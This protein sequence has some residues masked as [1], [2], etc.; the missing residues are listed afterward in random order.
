VGLVAWLARAEHQRE[1]VIVVHG[2]GGNRHTSLA[3]ASFLFPRF[4]TLL[5]DLRGHGES[6]GRHT[7]VGYLERL[8]VA[9]AVDYLRSAGFERVG[10]LGISMGAVTALLAAADC[11]GV[12]AVVADSPFAALQFAVQEGARLRGYPASI[13]RPLAYLSCRTAA[14]RLRHP[15]RAGDPLRVVGAIAPRPIMLIHG[16][17]DGLIP[18]ENAHRLYAAA[19]DPKELWTLPDVA[20]ARALEATPHYYSRRVLA[21]FERWLGR[22][23]GGVAQGSGSSSSSTGLLK[24]GEPA[25]QASSAQVNQIAQD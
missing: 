21:Y 14:W 10:V 20:H 12:D 25:S 13:V 4:A 24:I 23:G 8:D 5:L 17:A 15:L 16:E 9:A 1:A 7:S 11:S 18:V 6:E 22:P 19:Q 3:Y 2:H